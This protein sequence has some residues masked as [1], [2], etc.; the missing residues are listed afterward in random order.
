MIQN[1][2][3]KLCK[4]SRDHTTALSAPFFLR[5]PLLFSVVLPLSL[6]FSLLGAGN[7]ERQREQ[8]VLIKDM[9][10]PRS[11]APD[12]HPKGDKEIS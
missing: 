5:F 9:P 3:E 8:S 2:E 7:E 4:S 6:S 11:H 10:D 12:I 1:M